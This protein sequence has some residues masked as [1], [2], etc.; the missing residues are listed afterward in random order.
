M[1]RII[2]LMIAPNLDS[3]V[4]NQAAQDYKNNTWFNKAKQS[5]QQYAKWCVK[6]II[7]PISCLFLIVLNKINELLKKILMNF[8]INAV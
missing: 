7:I 3:P 5:T 2:S 8:E 6:F 4:N 1:E